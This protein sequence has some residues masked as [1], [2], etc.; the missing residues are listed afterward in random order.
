MYKRQFVRQGRR[1]KAILLTGSH[2]PERDFGNETTRK[3]I[4]TR[5]VMRHTDED[6]ARASVRFL[7]VPEDDPMFE[8]LVEILRT[9]TSPVDGD[10]SGGVHPDRRGECFIRDAF[11]TIGD[12][13]ILGPA[14]PHLA[15]A[16]TSTP[17]KSKTV[18]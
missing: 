5:I 9:D 11:G 15:A 14:Q 7:G 8:Q 3:L 10:S 6:L 4:P 12:A 1:P 2:D 18:I 13:R 17:P 16:V